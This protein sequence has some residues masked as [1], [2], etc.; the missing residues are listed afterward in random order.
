[1]SC[2]LNLSSS[3][4]SRESFASGSENLGNTFCLP[5]LHN[6]QSRD[7]T[8]LSRSTWGRQRETGSLSAFITGRCLTS[9][10]EGKICPVW[11]SSRPHS[12]R[13][14]GPRYGPPPSVSAPSHGQG[15]HC[16]ENIL[17]CETWCRGLSKL[18]LVQMKILALL[19]LL[20]SLS[21]AISHPRSAKTA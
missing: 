20:I 7:S 12:F 3:F 5:T 15:A 10:Q 1:M 16:Q 17:L 8:R 14:P 6:P 19:L 2:R 9:T 11:D 13:A 21:R 4:L 18:E